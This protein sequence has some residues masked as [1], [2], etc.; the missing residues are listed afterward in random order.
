MYCT[1]TKTFNH[2]F[3]IFLLLLLK[4]FLKTHSCLNRFIRCLIEEKKYGIFSVIVLYMQFFNTPLF[5]QHQRLSENEVE[6]RTVISENEIS[7]VQMNKK[8]F[9]ISL[10]KSSETLSSEKNYKKAHTLE[11]RVKTI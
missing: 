10:G 5:L 9:S 4:L 3:N 11:N 2:W 7:K 6:K 8:K 1:Q